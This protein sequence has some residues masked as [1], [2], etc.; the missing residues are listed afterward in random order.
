[1]ESGRDPR[2]HLNRI[3][4]ETDRRPVKRGGGGGGGGGGDTQDNNDRNVVEKQ[5]LVL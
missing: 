4:D 1:M 2:D 3:K 5:V